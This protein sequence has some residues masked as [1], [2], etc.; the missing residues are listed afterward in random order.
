M[1]ELFLPLRRFE[2][3]LD[4]GIELPVCSVLPFA[5]LQTSLGQ[6]HKNLCHAPAGGLLQKKQVWAKAHNRQKSCTIPRWEL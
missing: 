1:A 6:V 4:G 5:I 3:I 2:N